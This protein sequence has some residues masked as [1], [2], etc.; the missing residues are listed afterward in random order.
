[1]TN[2]N[3]KEWVST[4]GDDV[5]WKE[6]GDGIIRD[7]SKVPTDCALRLM[8]LVAEAE[9]RGQVKAWIEARQM[10]ADELIT[11][12][13]EIQPRQKPGHGPCCT[14]QTCGFS[15]SDG[16]EC[17]CRSNEINGLIEAKLASLDN[18]SK[19]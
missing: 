5:W 12:G 9:R 17:W 8:Q 18:S 10:L 7:S 6:A 11:K 2:L 13:T 14:C 15:Y 4:I 3:E 1:M 16:D 19:G